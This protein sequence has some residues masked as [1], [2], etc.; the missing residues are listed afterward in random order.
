MI[1]LIA[2]Q[3]SFYS[4]AFFLLVELTA[5][6]ATT[7]Y[8]ALAIAAALGWRSPELQTTMPVALVPLYS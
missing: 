7:T 5:T 8:L 1:I 3:S 4:S 2:L 6:F